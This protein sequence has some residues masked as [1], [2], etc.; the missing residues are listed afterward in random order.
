MTSLD[1]DWGWLGV[2]MWW[3]AVCL[4]GGYFLT[5]AVGYLVGRIHERYILHW[6]HK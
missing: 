2:S 4:P 5:A 3:S 1:I 6:E